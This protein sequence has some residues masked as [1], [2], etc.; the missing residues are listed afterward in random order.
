MVQARIG[1][2]L[3]RFF[4]RNKYKEPAYLAIEN[5]K[6]SLAQVDETSGD[7]DATRGLSKEIDAQ[8]SLLYKTM[9]FTFTF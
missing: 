9:P 3:T 1:L 2:Q 8:E 4:M 6:Q 7:P 5:A